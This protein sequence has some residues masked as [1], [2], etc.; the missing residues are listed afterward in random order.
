[1]VGVDEEST[2]PEVFG[3][4]SGP[5]DGFLDGS[6]GHGTFVAGI[7]RQ[8]APDANVIAVRVADSDGTVLESELI[9]ALEELVVQKERGVIQLDILNLSLGFYHETPED[10]RF[11]TRLFDV[12]KDLRSHGVIVVCSAGNDATDRPAFPAALTTWTG[13]DLN[14]D[15]SGTLAEHLAVGALNPNGRS[16][17]LYSNIGNWVSH[18][19]PGTSVLSTTPP[20]EGGLQ[21]ASRADLYDRRR[22][23]IDGDDFT[24][25]FAIW[26]G[27]SFAAPYVAG[28]IA[29]GLAKQLMESGTRDPGAVKTAV[30]ELAKLDRSDTRVFDDDGKRR[31]P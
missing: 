7:I 4:Q 2:D 15:E 27:T 26:S 10:G 12:L 13:S 31:A 1:V 9:G 11:S 18:F 29:Q 24:G 28:V 19:A 20:L 25:G 3:D 14:L 30:D 21:A 17:A 16:V 6:A 5:R 8:A 22:M 23:T